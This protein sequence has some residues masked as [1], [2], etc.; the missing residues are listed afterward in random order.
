MR[1]KPNRKVPITKAVPSPVLVRRRPLTR[2]A[3]SG[4]EASLP[5]GVVLLIDVATVGGIAIRQSKRLSQMVAPHGVV[6]GVDNVV[7]VVVAEHAGIRRDQGA[8][9]VVEV[10]VRALW[11]TM[12]ANSLTAVVP[13]GATPF[14]SVNCQVLIA[15]VEF[16]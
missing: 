7:A 14:A 6:G 8:Y 3:G 5:V 12:S 15:L 9:E 4:A 10:A 13:A 2:G 1:S 11:S 16:R